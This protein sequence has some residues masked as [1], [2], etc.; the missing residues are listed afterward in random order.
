MTFVTPEECKR[1]FCTQQL[2]DLI[3]EVNKFLVKVNKVTAP[4]RHGSNQRKG[5]MDDL[6]NAQIDLEDYLRGGVGN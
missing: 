4:H 1:C 2:E 3:K 6:S 5:A